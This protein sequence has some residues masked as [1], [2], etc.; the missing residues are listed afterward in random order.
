MILNRYYLNRVYLPDSTPGSWHD[1]KGTLICKTLEL[2]WRNNAISGDPRK[3]S[4]IVE[5]VYLFV[6]QPPTVLRNYEYYRAVHVPGRHWSAATG[7]SS[8]LVHPANL[9][10]QLLGCIAP[11][12][13]HVDINQDKIIDIVDSK[14][15]LKWMTSNL[16]TA[17]ELEIR[18]KQ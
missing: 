1:D 10:D 16:P 14:A 13:R 5:G 17:F 11:G 12:S 9:A 3:A 15:K 7:M 2:T 18:K 4:C 6:W 8:V